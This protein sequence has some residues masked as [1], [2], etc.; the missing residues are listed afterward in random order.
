MHDNRTW[1]KDDIGDLAGQTAVVTGASAGIGLET[2]RYLAAHGARVVLACRDQDRGQRAAQQITGA[3]RQPAVRAEVLDLADLASVR[4]FADRI[5]ARHAGIDVLVN[6]AAI[7]GGPHRRTADG[8]EAHL[9]TN[10]L[11]HFALTGLLL[12]ALLTRPGARVVTLTSSVAA[13]GRIDFADLNSERHYRFVAAYSQAKLANLMFA[14]ELDRRAKAAELPLASIAA[15]PGVVMTSLLR[16]KRDQWGRGPRPA[17]MAVA[18]IQRL[19][20]QPPGHGCLTSLY[21]ATAPGLRGGEYIA[22][23]SRAHKRGAPAPADPPRHAID[24]ATAS[25]LWETSADLTGVSYSAL[26]SPGSRDTATRNP[27]RP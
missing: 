5:L 22:P 1:S 4:R 27:G 3:R 15:N 20:G 17:E 25:Q 11:G 8:F 13:Q 14:I 2:A 6:N 21:A 7:A 16:S 23:G 26:N 24:P 18:T 10:H 9:G 12:P 19:F